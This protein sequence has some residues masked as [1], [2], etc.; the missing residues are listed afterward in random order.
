MAWS[1]PSQSLVD[2]FAIS[3][4]EL[5]GV[6][7]RKMFGFPAAFVNGYVFAGVFEDQMFARLSPE[8]G[9]ALVEERG[10]VPFAPMPGRSMKAYW[11]LPDSV[12]DDEAAVAD[13]LRQACRFTAMLPPKVKKRRAVKG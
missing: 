13:L 10:A 6:T 12:V 4:P 5:P 2:L 11:V 9:A 8:T 7:H 3:L 1:K